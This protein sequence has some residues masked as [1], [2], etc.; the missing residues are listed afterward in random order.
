MVMRNNR[1]GF[2]WFILPLMGL[3]IGCSTT[4]D[5]TVAPFIPGEIPYQHNSKMVQVSSYDTTGGNNDRFNIHPGKKLELMDAQG[6]GVIS[7]IWLTIDSRDP[8]YLRNI[9]V[10]MYWDGEDKPSVEVPI[11]DLFGSG[12][13][14]KHYTAQLVGMSSGGYYLYFPMPFQER[15]RIEVVNQSDQEVFGFYYHINYYKMNESLPDNTPYFHARWQ[16]DIRTTDDNNF[17]ALNAKGAGYFVGM[18]F[19]GQPYDS[20]LV[21]LEGDEMIYVDGEESPSIH[22]TGFEDYF[23]SGWYFKNG[24]Y[25]APYHGLVDLEQET[26]RVTAY[27]HH[28]PDAIPFRD[29]IKVTYEHGHGNEAVSD[30]TTTA[31][32][33]QTEPHA[34]YDPI[35]KATLRAPLS[36]LVSVGAIEAQSLEIEGTLRSRV[37]NM[38]EYG[39]DWLGN[40]Q[41]EVLEFDGGSFSLVVNDAIE[42]AYTARLYMTAGPDYGNVNISQGGAEIS[43]V[44]YSKT[45]EPR[46]AITLNNIEADGDKLTIDFE[47][48]GKHEASSGYK[49]GIDAIH[50]TPKREFISEW[51]IIG[52]FA[53]PRESDD[54]RFGLDSVYVPEEKINLNASYTGVNGQSVGWQKVENAAGYKMNLAGRLNPSEFVIS[55]ALTYVYSPHK[56]SVPLMLGSDDGAKVFLNDEELFKIDEVR[57]AVPDQNEITLNLDK[58][59]NKLLIKAENN[60]GGYGFYARI[61]DLNENL[62]IDADRSL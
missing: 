13:K 34:N 20:S 31:Y 36:R 17:V 24:E 26:G 57:S 42:D 27:R 47:V 62:T 10:R 4:D 52:P 51:Y 30:F 49:A 59:W 32:W 21:Y 29:S 44:G 43:F 11:G 25:N 3:L 12:F 56:Q 39:P 9:L 19:N 1:N 22:G 28:I 2:K 38:S 23:T 54:L 40:D 50:L 14:Y 6:P 61:I 7:R 60:I 46:E 58:G 35:K 15:A 8:D 55:Y 5:P 33:Y 48:T 18:N 53:N 41:L 16:R 37:M 45:V